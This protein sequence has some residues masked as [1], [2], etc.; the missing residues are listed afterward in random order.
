VSQA[1]LS[2]ATT[3]LRNMATIAGNILQRT[4]CP[5]F[6]DVHALCNRRQ[7]GSGCDALEGF[8]RGHALLGVSEHCIA[9]HPRTVFGVQIELD[10]P[11]AILF[12]SRVHNDPRNGKTRIDDLQAIFGA[13]ESAVIDVRP[14]GRIARW[15]LVLF[16][17][18]LGAR[19]EVGAASNNAE[20]SG[21]E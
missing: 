16:E 21:G 11:I 17:W 14:K 1:I 19:R 3:Q 2:G 5:Y 15:S 12:P 7:P 8:N 18:C 20:Q 13:G 9:T 6:R 10:V 4:R